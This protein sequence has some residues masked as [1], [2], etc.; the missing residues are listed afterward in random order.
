MLADTVSRV[1]IGLKTPSD[2][3]RQ[4]AAGRENSPPIG[5]VRVSHVR[6]CRVDRLIGSS[7]QFTAFPGDPDKVPGR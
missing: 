6:D 5:H 7:M 1:A 3:G 2:A 4:L